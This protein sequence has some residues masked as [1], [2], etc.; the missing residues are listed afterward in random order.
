M[1]PIHPVWANGPG[2]GAAAV[3]RCEA[4]LQIANITDALSSCIFLLR[5]TTSVDHS[6]TVSY[7]I[8]VILR[9]PLV[10][11]EGATTLAFWT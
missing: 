4:G 11:P 10:W 5:A 9:S 3:I 2:W 8:F 7:S 1:G 6:C